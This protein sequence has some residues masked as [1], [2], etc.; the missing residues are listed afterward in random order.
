VQSAIFAAVEDILQPQPS[1]PAG[2]RT[3]RIYDVLHSRFVLKLTQEE[4]A[5][6]LHMSI[7]SVKRAQREAV[8]TLARQ[9]WQ[10][11]RQESSPGDLAETVKAKKRRPGTQGHDAQAADWRSQAKHELASL[12]ASAPGVVSNVGETI[13]RVLE[14]E[15]ARS[16]WHDV[17]AD[18]AF[19]QPGL[20]AAIH[21]SVLRQILIAVLGRLARRTSTGEIQ[22]Y[23]SL[24]DGNVKITLATTISAESRINENEFIRDI[25]KPDDVSITV[26]IEGEH[27]FAHVRAPSPGKITVLVIDDNSDLVHFYRRATRGTKYRIVHLAEGEGALEEIRASTPDVI[28]LDVMLPDIDG[29]ELLMRLYEST[30]T[31]SIPVIICS[32]VREKELALSLGASLYLSKP[33]EAEK[34]RQ[35]LD[36]A[37]SLA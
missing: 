16:S 5:S 19:V 1:T 4:T 31:R 2:A 14:L 36:Q 29:W 3:K 34:F 37:L 11:F 33:V 32:V 28:V 21:P 22:V 12:Q 30:A 8:H 24:E 7:S 20:V 27:T 13:R 15:R 35:A 10:R 6:R 23:A 17:H 25:L 9:L 26:H 18:M